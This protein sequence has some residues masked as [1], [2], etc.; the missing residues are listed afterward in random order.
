MA[1]PQI[2][3]YHNPKCSKSRECASTTIPKFPNLNIETV[4]Y[5]TSPPSVEDLRLIVGFLPEEARGD[6]VRT[7]DLSPEEKNAVQSGSIDIVVEVLQKDLAKRLQRP[8]VVDWKAK[9]AAIGR[10]M[11]RVEELLE[12]ADK[13]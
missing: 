9:K 2:T 3:F 6:I 7:D 5:T 12:T 11:D 1:R 4:E 8:L 13:V 10:P